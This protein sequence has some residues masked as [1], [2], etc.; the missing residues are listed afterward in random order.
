MSKSGQNSLPTDEEILS[1]VNSDDLFIVAVK[2]HQFIDDIL[3]GIISQF[4]YDSHALEL[5]RLS[6]LLKVDLCIAL[7]QFPKEIRSRFEKLNGIR[8]KFAHNRKATLE[9]SKAKELFEMLPKR[10]QEYGLRRSGNSIDSLA[11]LQ[12]AI[13]ATIISLHKTLIAIRERK[14]RTRVAWQM[15]EENVPDIWELHNENDWFDEEIKKRI[16]LLREKD[17]NVQ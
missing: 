16:R 15:V 14:L 17:N 1:V 3:G 2:G 8:N 13:A 5:K 12:V 11:M 9:S 4:L 6:V 7:G 10:V